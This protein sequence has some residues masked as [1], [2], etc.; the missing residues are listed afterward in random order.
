MTTQVMATV[1][2]GQLK[3][4]EPV[5]LPNDSRVKLVL[6]V[7]EVE[8]TEEARCERKRRA[9][10][11]LLQFSRETPMNSGGMYFTRD[12]LHERD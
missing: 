9:L 2:D 6:E 1:V 4:D 3:L 8:E 12:Q 5:G 10:A 7:E 11:D